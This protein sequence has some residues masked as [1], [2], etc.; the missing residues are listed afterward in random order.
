MSTAVSKDEKASMSIGPRSGWISRSTDARL[1]IVWASLLTVPARISTRKMPGTARRPLPSIQN[2]DLP[3]TSF[4]SARNGVPRVTSSPTTGPR[5][6]EL[7]MFAGKLFMMPPST[8]TSPF[9]MKGGTMPGMADE[10]RSAS[11]MSPA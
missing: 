10:A 1:A 2:R 7:M 8:R 3:S 6:S 9:W 11:Q 5:A 4:S